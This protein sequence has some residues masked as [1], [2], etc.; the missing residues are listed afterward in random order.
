MPLILLSD[1]FI[2]LPNFM[3]TSNLV[4][5]LFIS[6]SDLLMIKLRRKYWIYLLPIYLV[7]YHFIKGTLCSSL[8]IYF[9]SNLQE[10]NKNLHMLTFTF[11][12]NI[13]SKSEYLKQYFGI[14]SRCL[15]TCIFSSRILKIKFSF[16]Y[17]D[18]YFLSHKIPLSTIFCYAE[19]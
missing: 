5:I 2:L 9:S 18:L 16:A 15:L 6:S 8:T 3:F 7:K 12:Y 14:V 13:F 4:S 19:H 10:K 1:M 17:Y 11:N